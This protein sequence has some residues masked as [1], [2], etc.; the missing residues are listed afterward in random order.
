M[1]HAGRLYY[2]PDRQNVRALLSHAQ[3]LFKRSVERVHT[4]HLNKLVRAALVKNP[5]PLQKECGKNLLRDASGH[6]AANA[7]A[8]AT[9]PPFRSSTGGIC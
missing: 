5:P 4:S 7:G 1:A 3:N 9:S 2:R 8:D 6:P